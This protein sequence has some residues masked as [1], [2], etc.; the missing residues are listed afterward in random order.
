MY[1]AVLRYYVAFAIAII[2]DLLDYTVLGSLPIIGDALDAVTMPIL[3]TLIGKFSLL[4]VL[5]F[6]PCRSCPNLHDS[7]R[8]VLH[9]G[10][11]K[12]AGAFA[13]AQYVLLKT[14]LAYNSGSASLRATS[15]PN[16]RKRYP[17]ITVVMDRLTL[18]TK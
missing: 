4:G 6:V 5:E 2:S 18:Y 10:A 3:Y 8:P 11:E 16:R 7:C 15:H 17:L 13:A 1:A 14:C 9:E 12:A